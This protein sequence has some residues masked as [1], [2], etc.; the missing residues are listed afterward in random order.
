MGKHIHMFSF[1]HYQKFP[2]WDKDSENATVC[3]YVRKNITC[4]RKKVTCKSCLR[5]MGIDVNADTAFGILER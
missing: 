4:N 5:E 3:G 2:S 1:E